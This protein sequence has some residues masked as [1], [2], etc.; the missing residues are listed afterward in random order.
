MECWLWQF[1]CSLL[2]RNSICNACD[3]CF[4][5]CSAFSAAGSGCWLLL[6]GCAALRHLHACHACRLCTHFRCSLIDID[7]RRRQLDFSAYLCWNL[8]HFT[9]AAVRH[10]TR[11]LWTYHSFQFQLHVGGISR[12]V[13]Y[14]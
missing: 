10:D 3:D 7:L 11:I 14:V 5:L 1:E 6:D 13:A 12:M 2:C 4:A 9:N 8:L